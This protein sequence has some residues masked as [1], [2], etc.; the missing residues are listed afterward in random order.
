VVSSA[1]DP[2]ALRRRTLVAWTAIAFALAGCG[3]GSSSDAETEPG[4]ADATDAGGGG[5]SGAGGSADAGG[6]GGNAGTGGNGGSAGAGGNGGS[7]GAGGGTSDAGTDAPFVTAPHP[8]A[9][10]VDSHGGTV[11]SQPKVLPIIY[12]ND[13]NLAVVEGFVSE[14]TATSWWSD[15]ASQYGVGALTVLPAIVR[16][17]A[18]PSY[19]TPSLI[20]SEIAAHTTPRGRPASSSTASTTRRTSTACTCR[21]P[22][23][24]RARGSTAPRTRTRSR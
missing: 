10:L 18:V 14:L 9:P 19:V 5:S 13:A 21:T 11:L 12:A 17:D 15:V 24:S 2:C 1:I 8:P 7:A 16:T 20:T 23:S 6:A 22:R 3:G 4:G